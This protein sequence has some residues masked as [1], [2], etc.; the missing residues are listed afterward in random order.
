MAVS[1]KVSEHHPS[2]NVQL[3]KQTMTN[4]LQDV[5]KRFKRN[6]DRQPSAGNEN[7]VNPQ[8]PIHSENDDDF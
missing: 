8:S 7:A 3:I 2:A 4:K 6:T 1:A 5:A